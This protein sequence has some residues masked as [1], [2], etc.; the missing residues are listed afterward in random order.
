[1]F[2]ITKAYY[3]SSKECNKVILT[4]LLLET[5]VSS[6]SETLISLPEEIQGRIGNILRGKENL[7]S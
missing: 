5:F 7:N 1:M 6:V 4:P 2:A 3:L